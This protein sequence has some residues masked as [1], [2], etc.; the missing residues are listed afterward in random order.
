MGEVMLSM[1]GINYQDGC[2]WV[3]FI[4]GWVVV[5]SFP[6][7]EIEGFDQTGSSIVDSFKNY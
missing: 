2:Y 5:L 7:M 3:K 4:S 1:P 6:L